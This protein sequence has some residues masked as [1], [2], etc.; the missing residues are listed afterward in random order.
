MARTPRPVVSALVAAV[1]V[2]TAALGVTGSAMPAFADKKPKPPV[3]LSGKVTNKGVGKVKSGAVAIE[4]DDF[5]FAKTFLKAE[6]G[7]V[8][9][10]VENAGNAPHTFTIDAQE[11]D[12]EIAPGESVTVT[13][14]VTDGDPVTFYCRFHGG[15]GMKGAFFTASGATAKAGTNGSNGSSGDSGSGSYG[16]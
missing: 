8:E 12:E 16:Y 2:G 15:G 1:M 5:S 10:T 11:I 4:A 6:P 14:D 3:K 9:V 13:V 7:S